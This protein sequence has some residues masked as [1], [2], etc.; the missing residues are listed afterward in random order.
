MATHGEKIDELTRLGTQL[1]E[2]VDNV[3]TELERLTDR[4]T[5]LTEQFTELDKQVALHEHQL[6]ELRQSWQQTV[7]R[8]WAILGPIVGATVA[9]LLGYLFRK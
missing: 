8:V 7:Q 9:A 6:V 3:R 5:T 4:L 1:T 2:R